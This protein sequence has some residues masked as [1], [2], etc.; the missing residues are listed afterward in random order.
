MERI[1][2]S[3][4]V[5]GECGV[6]I[7]GPSGSGKSSL[8]RQLLFEAGRGGRFA[9]L[10]S[11]DRLEV[12]ARHGR[13]LARA[14]ALI[15]GRLEIRGVGIVALRHERAAVIRV[16]VDCEPEKP[17]RLPA[18]AETCTTVCDIRLRRMVHHGDPALAQIVACLCGQGDTVMTLL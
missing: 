12:E 10:V 5:L 15:E 4:V 14:V 8:A 1:H 9:R 7:R 16:V 13:V 2:A 11:D 6:L 3:C 18:S 17:S